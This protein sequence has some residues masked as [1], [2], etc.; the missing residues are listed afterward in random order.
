MI[1]ATILAGGVGF[2]VGVCPYGFKFSYLL[3][4]YRRAEDP[5]TD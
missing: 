4:I 5:G 3:D 2:R 1:T